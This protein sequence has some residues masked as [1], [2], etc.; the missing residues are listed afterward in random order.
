MCSS[1]LLFRVLYSI[2]ESL[3]L[4]SLSLFLYV[5]YIPVYIYVM[6][7]RRGGRGERLKEEKNGS[8][9]EKYCKSIFC[10]I[11]FCVIVSCGKAVSLEKKKSCV[12]FE[13]PSFFASPSPST[14][15]SLSFTP[16]VLHVREFIFFMAYLCE[17]PRTKGC[18]CCCFFILLY[19]FLVPLP[20]PLPLPPPSSSSTFFL[21]Y[22]CL[23]LQ[24]FVWYCIG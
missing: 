1:H 20:L 17:D 5:F 21:L 18:C 7:T 13:C 11:I 10:F 8:C 22:F 14:S 12:K 4:Q 16:L 9:E 3:I 6:E 24:S 19:F 23:V 15:P 2:D